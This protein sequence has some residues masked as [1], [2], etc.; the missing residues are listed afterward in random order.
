MPVLR[1]NLALRHAAPQA[2]PLDLGH[3]VAALASAGSGWVAAS[4]GG[5]LAYR[6]EGAVHMLSALTPSIFNELAE[7]AASI[8]IYFSD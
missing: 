5:M 1:G 3:P 8:F 6:E 7:L 2:V 4:R